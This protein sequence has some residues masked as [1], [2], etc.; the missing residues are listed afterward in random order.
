MLPTFAIAGA[1][2]YSLVGATAVLAGQLR[3]PLTAS[4]LLFELTR[5]YRLIIP[6]IAA[7]GISSWIS[8]DGPLS[9]TR[10]TSVSPAHLRTDTVALDDVSETP[11][12]PQRADK[13]NALELGEPLLKGAQ[14]N[15]SDLTGITL[16]DAILL[17]NITTLPADMSVTE[18]LDQL[19][20]CGATIAIVEPLP[21]ARTQQVGIL[22]AQDILAD[23]MSSAAGGYNRSER[24]EPASV[25]GIA[26]RGVACFRGDAPVSS[27]LLELH[28][29]GVEHVV[30]FLAEDRG[31]EVG[32]P[33]GIVTLA[34]IEI[35]RQRALLKQSAEIS[36]RCKQ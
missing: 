9:R 30:A 26:S 32:K 22:T 36:A 5:D 7:A 25:G 29:P 8:N 10:V 31:D 14:D 15:T 23:R 21:D 27:V 34:S 19:V 16:A 18:A 17:S 28:R 4:L 6:L 13:R 3:A 2:A 11:T 1:P 20:Q 35:A 33:F 24:V 12:D